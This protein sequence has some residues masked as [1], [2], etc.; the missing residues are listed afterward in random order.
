MDGRIAACRNTAFF[1]PFSDRGPKQQ[2]QALIVR[3]N[4]LQQ[5]PFLIHMCYA[6]IRSLQR[7]LRFTLRHC[8]PLRVTARPRLPGLFGC[9]AHVHW[10]WKLHACQFNYLRLSFCSAEGRAGNH[11][12]RVHLLG[13]SAAAHAHVLPR[14]GR[15]KLGRRTTCLSANAAFAPLPQAG[16][17]MEGPKVLLRACKRNNVI[18]APKP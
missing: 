9:L 18:K 14:R 7:R 11:V 1:R 16:L 3:T 2:L 4:H 10:L 8:H 13:M 12:V 5:H 6:C 17:D 15:R